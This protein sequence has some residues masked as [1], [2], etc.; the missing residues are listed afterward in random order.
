MNMKKIR[1]IPFA[2]GL[3]LAVAPAL[4][5]QTPAPSAPTPQSF[6]KQ[7]T[8]SVGAKY[9]LSLPEGYGRDRWQRWPLVLFLHGSGERGDDLKKV[10]VHG[11][12]KQAA[13]GKA[14]PFILVSPQCPAGQSWDPETLNALL[15]EVMARYA[16]DADRVYL[17]GLSMG[18]FGTWEL[19]ARSPERFAAIAPICGGGWRR[20]ARRLTNVPVWAFHGDQ[21]R[22][23]PLADGKEMVEA[24]T[25]AGG[26]ATLTVYPGV[27][28]DSWTRTYENPEFYAWLLRHH[29]V[30]RNP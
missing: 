14:F 20:W 18:G 3:A 13:Q 30:A 27:G 12:P 6:Q 10:T 22:A 17:T 11:P 29:R 28:H 15:D 1:R 24:V 16:V 9:L 19:A 25:A 7:I 4:W 23:V 2:L 21:D 8:R 26:D 5:A